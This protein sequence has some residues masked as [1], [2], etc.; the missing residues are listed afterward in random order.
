MVFEWSRADERVLDRYRFKAREAVETEDRLTARVLVPK[1]KELNPSHPETLYVVARFAE[2]QGDSVTAL[3]A[4]HKLAPPN[5]DGF[6][7]AHYWMARHLLSQRNSLEGSLCNVVIHHLEQACESQYHRRDAHL[8]LAKILVGQGRYQE[9]V[10]HFE[11]VVPARPEF[12]LP[13]SVV[14]DALGESFRARAER[15]RA[16]ECFREQL[17]ADQTNIRSRILLAQTLALGG[18]GSEA[19][20]VLERGLAIADDENLRRAF[21]EISAQED[22][23]D[24]QPREV[25]LRLDELLRE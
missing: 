19:I 17:E 2:L 21:V 5:R 6:A 13:L 8:H 16:K 3:A 10:E 18:N 14:H 4:M 9:A 22:L 7:A 20:E 25:L 24:R 1:L 12:G 11:A 23:G 15:D